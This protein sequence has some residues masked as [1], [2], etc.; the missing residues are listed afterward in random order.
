MSLKLKR[1]GRTVVVAL[2]GISSTCAFSLVGHKAGPKATEALRT[3]YIARLQQQYVPATDNRTMGSLWSPGASLGDFSADYK[4]LRLNDTVTIEVS[5]QTNAA[6]SGTVD[7]ERS[8]STSSAL[9]GVMG[10]SPASTNPLL[11]GNSSSVLKGQG[12]TASN[13]TFQTNLT[14][15]VIAVLP[16][17]NL[18]VEAERQI[19][20]NNQHENIVVRGMIRPGDIGP[21]NTVAS[22]ALSNLEIEMKG[23]GIISDGVR[24]PN[25]LTKAVLWLLN[26]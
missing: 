5:V 1:L 4:A 15:Q 21:G 8:F 22:T 13:T 20:M 23:K 19:F 7:S 24:P 12:A 14:G 3:Q 25:F 10:K 9:T 16:N 17:G 18:V 6:Q 26:F 11:A 2:L